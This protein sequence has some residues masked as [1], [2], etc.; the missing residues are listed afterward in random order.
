MV[1]GPLEAKLA[2]RGIENKVMKHKIRIFFYM[3]PGK[4]SAG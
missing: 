1:F 4:R 2:R 3:H